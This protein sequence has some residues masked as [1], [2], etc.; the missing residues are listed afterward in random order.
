ML[1]LTFKGPIVRITPDELHIK[2]SSFY[3]EIYAGGLR[4]RN[5]DERF[6]KM[7]GTPRALV[8]IAD[9]A[10][11]CV[12]RSLLGEFFSKRSIVKME[13]IIND[14]IDKLSQRL[15]DARKTGVVINMDAAFAAMTADVIT[16]HGWGQ[17]GNYLEHGSFNKQWKDAVIGT[18]GS[19]VLFRHF[20]FMLNILTAMP[21][22][23]L[24][25]ID[26]GVADILKIEDL[27][28][29]LSIE[30]VNRGATR[31]QESKT[32]FDALNDPDLPPDQRTAEHLVDEGHILLLAGT[33]TTAKALTTGLCYL[34]L[35]EN[36]NVLMTLQTELRQAYPDVS[37]WP[38]WNEAQKLPYLVSQISPFCSKMYYLCGTNR[39]VLSM[40]V[41]ACHMV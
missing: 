9:N 1:I 13:P 21:L 26:L 25:W 6:V 28:R 36:K 37:T 18:M 8:A 32:I 20:P 15:C 34:L 40:S 41:F 30:N 14:A 11:H 39:R 23:L 22:S 16:R 24:L 12:R 35:P 2:D 31:K 4:V 33:E 3:D 10:H 5:K 38:T 29:R 27:V 19:R 17:S 7:F